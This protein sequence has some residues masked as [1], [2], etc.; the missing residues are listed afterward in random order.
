MYLSILKQF[1]SMSLSNQYCEV[2]KHCRHTKKIGCN[3]IKGINLYAKQLSNCLCKTWKHH[4]C[5]RWSNASTESLV[6]E[7][8][9]L[10][11]YSK[12]GRLPEMKRVF[13]AMPAP[14]RVS[15]NCLISGYAGRGFLIQSVKSYNMIL[16]DGSFNLVGLDYPLCLYLHLMRIMFFWVRRFMGM[17]WNVVSVSCFCWEFFGAY[18][19]QNGAIFCARQGFDEMSEKNMVV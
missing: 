2:L 15:W 14:D 7:H 18:V 8:T 1:N 13:D 19:L 3:I 10:S 11:S 4:L 16:N 9:S 6:L 5:A 12:L 17:W